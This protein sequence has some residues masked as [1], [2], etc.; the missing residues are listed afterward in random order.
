MCEYTAAAGAIRVFGLM[1]SFDGFDIIISVL[2]PRR[3]AKISPCSRPT[4]LHVLPKR[5]A[6]LPGNVRRVS[7]ISRNSRS[8][9]ALLLD[10]PFHVVS[11]HPRFLS[12]QSGREM[13]GK[14]AAS[15]SFDHLIN[16]PKHD[17]RTIRPTGTA[18][19]ARRS[20]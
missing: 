14:A 10:D 18:A 20:T 11:W 15:S 13:G 8:P 7:P 2:R 9:E 12:N 3:R 19:C 16:P 5:L 4:P 1:N 17:D 6:D